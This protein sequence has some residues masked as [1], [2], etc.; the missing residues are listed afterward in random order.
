MTREP[1]EEIHGR[2][3]ASG[4]GV[5]LADGSS[6]IE[7][8]APS[9][10]A[11]HRHARCTEATDTGVLSTMHGRVKLSDTDTESRLRE[12][13][14]DQVVSWDKLKKPGWGTDG[15]SD[16]V[17]VCGLRG[18]RSRGVGGSWLPGARLGW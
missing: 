17:N 12:D 18:Q 10:P 16:D 9:L 7:R 4:R 11:D 14:I 3:I 8:R 15:E 13:R 6:F 2:E 1:G 5:S